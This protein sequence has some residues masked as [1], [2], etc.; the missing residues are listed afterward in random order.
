MTANNQLEEI[1]GDILNFASEHATFAGRNKN[2]PNKAYRS[3]DA[4]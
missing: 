4:R 2:V 3:M 1:N